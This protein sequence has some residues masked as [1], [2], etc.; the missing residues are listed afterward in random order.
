MS[1]KRTSAIVVCQIREAPHVAEPDAVADA[2]EE[3][4]DLAPP[5]LPLFLPFLHLVRLFELLPLGGARRRRGCDD[6]LGDGKACV[7]Q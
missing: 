6:D 7:L 2:G 4:L 1:F 3:E 5:L